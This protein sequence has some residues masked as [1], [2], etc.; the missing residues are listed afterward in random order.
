MFT[1]T[2]SANKLNNDRSKILY[3]EEE[4]STQAAMNDCVIALKPAMLKLYQSRMQLILND[5]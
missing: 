4:Q 1:S 2:V 5:W 3:I